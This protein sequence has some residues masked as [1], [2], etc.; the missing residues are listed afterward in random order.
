MTSTA[1][2]PIPN[3][4]RSAGSRRFTRGRMRMP[5]RL[6]AGSWIAIWM[7]TPAGLPMAMIYSASCWSYG[8]TNEYAKNVTMTIRLF[9]TGA[10]DDHR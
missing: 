8:A 4:S 6:S 5:L 10:M 3:V 7:N 9:A 1:G 2:T